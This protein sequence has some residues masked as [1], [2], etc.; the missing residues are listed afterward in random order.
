MTIPPDE[1]SLSASEVFIKYV[2]FYAFPYTCKDIAS[3]SSIHQF[4]A[5][6]ICLIATYQI[7]L[8][9][10]LVGV[11]FWYAFAY[12]SHTINPLYWLHISGRQY[13]HE[14][15][16]EYISNSMADLDRVAFRRLMDS[17]VDSK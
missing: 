11:F 12:A 10:L 13:D 3:A 8:L 16:I 7:S 6:G 15:I 14:E 2:I 9:F 1:L 4:L 17:F 5:V